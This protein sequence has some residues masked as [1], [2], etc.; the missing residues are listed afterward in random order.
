MILKEWMEDDSPLV[1]FYGNTQSTETGCLEWTGPTDTDGYGRFK[2]GGAHRWL[3]I[4]L[5]GDIGTLHVLHSCD[6][7]PCVEITHLRAG[8]NAENMADKNR[9]HPGRTH[10]IN[11]HEYTYENTYIQPSGHRA[12]KVCRYAAHKRYRAKKRG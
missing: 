3:F 1:K 6:N 10:C 11:S 7:P 8:T 5:N 2:G 12:C 4:H 9:K